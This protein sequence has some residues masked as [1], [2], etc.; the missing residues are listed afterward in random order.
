MKIY[1]EAKMYSVMFKAISF[2]S[3]KL[4]SGEELFIDVWL[5]FLPLYIT[6]VL[7]NI[8]LSYDFTPK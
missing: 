7:P 4:R 2:V 8:F 6:Q 5:S 3:N 1:I